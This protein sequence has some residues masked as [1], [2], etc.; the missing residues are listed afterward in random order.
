MRVV[1]VGAFALASL[2]TTTPAEM[3][4]AA[5][6]PTDR[7]AV[8]VEL[9]SSEGCS[10]CPPAD[11]VLAELADK[12]P[13]AGADILALEMHVD[14]WNSLGW[15]DP[16]SSPK[17]SARQRAY[18]DAAGERGVYTPQMIVDGTAELIGSRGDAARAAIAAASR[19]AKAKVA[20][21]ARGDKVTIS[22]SELTDPGQPADVWLAITESNLKTA[23]PRGENAGATLAH[24]PVVRS[25]SKVG[26]AN[27]ASFSI[28]APLALDTSWLQENLRLV[29]FVQRRKTLNIVGAAS[30]DLRAR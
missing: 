29:A 14:Y 12:Q 20:L 6:K 1:F 2:C 23:V 26:G 8:V 22:I 13:V 18:A 25:L 4:T 21:V 17:L 5:A 11:S 19:S 30:V 9:F 10:S 27:G 15:V 28:E 7:R 3:G 16:F 24:G